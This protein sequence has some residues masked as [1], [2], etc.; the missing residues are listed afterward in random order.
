M[1]N[2]TL[3]QNNSIHGGSFH[4][5]H[6][7]KKKRQSQYIYYLITNV[8]CTTNK[9]VYV[10]KEY[11]VEVMKILRDEL[12]DNG[13]GFGRAVTV[14]AFIETQKRRAPPAFSSLRF[15]AVPEI[16]NAAQTISIRRQRES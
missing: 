10:G 13:F 7:R 8:L 11:K 3:K 4:S 5:S 16:E 14:S 9:L 2:V 15:L 12:E 1:G 6:Y